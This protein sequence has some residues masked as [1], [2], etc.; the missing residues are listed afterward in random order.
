MNT[1]INSL[2]TMIEE[3]QRKAEIMGNIFTFVFF[4]CIYLNKTYKIVRR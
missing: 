4:T 1:S 3:S 2:E